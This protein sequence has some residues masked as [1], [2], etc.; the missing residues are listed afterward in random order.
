MV[1]ERDAFFIS[2]SDIRYHNT[3][4]LRKAIPSLFLSFRFIGILL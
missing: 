2:G 1:K 3:L 4:L